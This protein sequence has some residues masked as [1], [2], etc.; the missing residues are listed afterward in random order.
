MSFNLL[1][2]ISTLIHWQGVAGI[3]GKRFV[4]ETTNESGTLRAQPPALRD[5]LTMRHKALLLL[6]AIMQQLPTED[7]R[8][9]AVKSS[10][11]SQEELFFRL[12]TTYDYYY[13]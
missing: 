5:Q 9:P 11:Q 13:N 2:V 12:K 3:G 4:T 10:S 1:Y 8:T 6:H 7:R